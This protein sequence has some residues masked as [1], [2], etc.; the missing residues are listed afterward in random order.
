MVNWE[1]SS[2]YGL[3][4]FLCIV[5]AAVGFCLVYAVAWQMGYTKH[6]GPDRFEISPEQKKYMW[7]VRERNLKLIATAHG[8]RHPYEGSES[9]DAGMSMPWVNDCIFFTDFRIQGE[10]EGD[11][12]NW[13]MDATDMH[14]SRRYNAIAHALCPFPRLRNAIVGR[15]EITP[16]V[17]RPLDI[18]GPDSSKA[19]PILC[20]CN[21]APAAFDRVEFQGDSQVRVREDRLSKS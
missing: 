16:A 1:D 15:C 20:R 12:W 4:M 18:K 9:N 17:R 21:R 7:E 10:L 2:N 8:W 5:G 19:A 3:A 6:H 13:L 14:A 11:R